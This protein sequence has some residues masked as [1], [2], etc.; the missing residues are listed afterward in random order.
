MTLEKQDQIRG[1]KRK[2]M[3]YEPLA[4]AQAGTSTSIAATSRYA[5]EPSIKKTKVAPK[6]KIHVDF[7]NRSMDEF[8]LTKEDM[9]R[10]PTSQVRLIPL[11]D[12]TTEE[13]KIAEGK[14]DNPINL[15][16]EDMEKQGT[17]ATQHEIT[18]NLQ[19]S[20]CTPRMF[21]FESLVGLRKEICRT[22]DKEAVEIFKRHL[23]L[24][25][26]GTRY[27]FIQSSTNLYMIRNN[28]VLYEFFYQLIIFS[29]GNIGAFDLIQSDRSMKFLPLTELLHL[30]LQ[31]MENN[32]ENKLDA[33][34]MKQKIDQLS[35]VLIQNRNM[36]W[37]YFSIKIRVKDNGQHSALLAAIPCLIHG[38][39]PELGRLPSL[40][41][42]LAQVDY[43]NEKNCYS[44]IASA[45][46]KFHLPFMDADNDTHDTIGD[47]LTRH[48][49]G[50]HEVVDQSRADADERRTM[51]RSAQRQ[52]RALVFPALRNRFLPSRTLREHIKLLISTAQAFKHFHRC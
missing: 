38:Y 37:N 48:S 4:A 24:G 17:A 50:S 27:A 2:I 45:L 8:V 13:E 15:D 34:E 5:F 52:L 18:N 32:D 41:F 21:E 33:I 25:F 43:T 29:F 11:M 1:V 6:D 51:R 23:L 46:A 36:L 7:T 42:Q 49:K 10:R 40:L 3:K 28:F 31:N 30:Y 20:K 39:V 26:S 19:I 35:D 44:G 47:R 22:A 9:R 12:V 16:N 14:A